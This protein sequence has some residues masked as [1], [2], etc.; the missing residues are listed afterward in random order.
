MHACTGSLVRRVTPEPG[1]SGPPQCLQNNSCCPRGAGHGSAALASLGAGRHEKSR[2]HP[3]W[4]C[5][6]ALHRKPA[7]TD[8][9]KGRLAGGGATFRH[10]EGTLDH[11]PTH[12][13]PRHT[14]P[15][16]QAGNGFVC[17]GH[18]PVATQTQEFIPRRLEAA[19]PRSSCQLRVQGHVLAVSLQRCYQA[20]PCRVLSAPGQES[21]LEH[22]RGLCSTKLL[23]SHI[24]EARQSSCTG[25]SPEAGLVA[26]SQGLT[27][28]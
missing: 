25:L 27:S 26:K 28:E 24:Q 22:Q 12:T 6:E 15:V 8:V 5:T 10:V 21:Q 17:W 14:H 23:T 20:V 9:C 18:C 11:S 2:Q 7:Q 16:H 19:R 4:S 1:C 3:Y 13:T